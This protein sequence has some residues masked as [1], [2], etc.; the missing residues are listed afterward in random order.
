[1]SSF[2]HPIPPPAPLIT[3]VH[4]P[5]RPPSHAQY[6]NYKGY[7]D[8]IAGG[9][10]TAYFDATTAGALGSQ[11]FCTAPTKEVRDAQLSFPSGHASISFT[12]MTVAAMQLRYALGV[13]AGILV[14]VESVA[15]ASPLIIAVWIAVTRVRDRFHNTVDVL[16]GALIGAIVGALVWGNHAAH[17]RPEVLPPALVPPPPAQP[18]GSKDEVAGLLPSTTTVVVAGGS[19]GAIRAAAAA[20]GSAASGGSTAGK[21]AAAAAVT[22]VVLQ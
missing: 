2:F 6:C 21:G 9:N 20:G 7:R 19:G 13:P 8:A 10:L 15:A 14:S 12:A 3:P 18:A 4:P 22:T 1:M 16:C 17:R 11:A 5:T